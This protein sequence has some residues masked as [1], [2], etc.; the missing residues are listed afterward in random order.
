MMKELVLIIEEQ[1]VFF[2]IKA[3]VAP[4][5]FRENGLKNHD[6]KEIDI[7][8]SIKDSGDIEKEQDLPLAHENQR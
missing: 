3:E 8:F 6:L 2:I 5:V 4:K 1:E 7:N